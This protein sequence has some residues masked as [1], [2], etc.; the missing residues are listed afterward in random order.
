MD[1]GYVKSVEGAEAMGT[2]LMYS[3]VVGSGPPE[4]RGNSTR[5]WFRQPS[6][7]EQITG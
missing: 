5:R 3:Q 6:Y 4:F 7:L 2:A 1:G